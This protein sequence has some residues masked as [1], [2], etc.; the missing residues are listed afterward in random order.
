MLIALR[1]EGGAAATA[2]QAFSGLV[3]RVERRH[4]DLAVWP[5]PPPTLAPMV[6]AVAVLAA[7]ETV[8]LVSPAQLGAV[9][10]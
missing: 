2:E 7:V 10:S 4:S 1:F 5:A 6:Q 9:A 8:H 3:V